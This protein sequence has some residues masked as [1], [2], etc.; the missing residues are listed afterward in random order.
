MF[1]L[2]IHF[3]GPC[4]LTAWFWAETTQFFSFFSRSII[5]KQIVV[6]VRS[7]LSLSLTHVASASP[8]ASSTFH[9]KRRNFSC[10]NHDF[11]RSTITAHHSSFSSEKKSSFCSDCYEIPKTEWVACNIFLLILSE[12]STCWHVVHETEHGEQRRFLHDTG[13]I[14]KNNMMWRLMIFFYCFNA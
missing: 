6:F 12:A 11:D 7:M 3:C 9:H 1:V 8:S 10:F 2:C 4:S 5:S 13:K 14:V